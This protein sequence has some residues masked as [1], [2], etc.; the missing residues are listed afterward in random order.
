MALLYRRDLVFLGYEIHLEKV[1]RKRI[2]SSVCMAE[3][4]KGNKVIPC[5]ATFYKLR[6]GIRVDYI[7]D[8]KIEKQV[9]DELFINTRQNPKHF[10]EYF[11]RLF[12]NTI[13]ILCGIMSFLIMSYTIWGIKNELTF[14]EFSR[15]YNALLCMIFCYIENYLISIL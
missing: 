9:I 13:A 11:L 7:V 12:V 4:V 10:V 3:M 1:R 15:I 6:N 2:L 14:P 8:R 5:V